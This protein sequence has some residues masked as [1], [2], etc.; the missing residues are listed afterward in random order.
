[1]RDQKQQ[2]YT[3]EH[4]ARTRLGEGCKMSLAECQIYAD[5]V[6]EQ[7][8]IPPVK[9]VKRQGERLSVYDTAR[10]EIKLSTWGMCEV[11]L[12]HELS[13]HVERVARAAGGH[14]PEFVATY[15]R[16]IE[17]N[18]GEWYAKGMRTEMEYMG[19]WCSATTPPKAAATDVDRYH[20]HQGLTFDQVKVGRQYRL[21]PLCKGTFAGQEVKVVKKNRS[22]VVVRGTGFRDSAIE[23]ALLVVEEV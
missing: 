14:G 7:E 6:C 1:M 3:A 9:V 18:L 21:G 2:L 5:T 20:S 17:E 16:L 13:H 19:V 8:G 4:T 12:L 23:P 10:K 22:K 15:L 11:V